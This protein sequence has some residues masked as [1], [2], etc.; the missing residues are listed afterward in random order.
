MRD[1]LDP[2]FFQLMAEQVQD[3]AIFLLDT[4]G[5]VLSW[6]LGGKRIKQ[7]D[8]SDVIG[9]HFS[10]FY[11]PPDIA[12]E[13]PAEELE[14]ALREG[15]FEDEGWRV[16]KD[17]SRFWA[18]VVI[19]ALRDESGKLIAYSKV[20]RDLSE[21]KRQDEQLRQSEERFRLLVEGVSDY[22]I[23]LLSPEGIVTS[24]NLGARRIKGYEA[25]EVI[26]HHF[27]RFYDAEGIRA[28]KPW[29]ELA[30]AREHGRAEDEGW[31]IRKDGSRFWAKVVVTALH[32]SDGRLQGFAKVTQDL[33]QRQHS[34]SLEE[35]AKNVGDFIAVLAHEL[36]NPLAPIR[37]AIQLLKSVDSRDPLHEKIRLILDRQSNQ[38]SLIVNDLL[39]VNRVA[40]GLLHLDM[41]P[42]VLSDVVTRAVEAAEPGITEK[43]HTLELDIPD[44]PIIINGDD[45]RLTQALSNIINNATRYS[46]NGGR[47]SIKIR[48]EKAEESKAVIVSVT[49]TGHGIDS[50]LLGSIFG[51]FVQGRDPLRS[52]GTG[53]GIGLALARSIVELHHGT[54]EAKSEGIGRGSEFT[55]KLPLFTSA[56]VTNVTRSTIAATKAYRILVVDDNEDAA[57][58]LGEL[59]TANGHEV[60][61]VHRGSQ[62]IA[63]FEEFCPSIVLLDIGMPGMSGLEVVRRL[64]ERS[65][66][67]RP[68][69][70][71]IT[72]WG[73][74]DDELRSRRAGFDFHLVK[75]VDEEKILGL[76][77]EY[78]Q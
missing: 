3:Y 56:N 32:G 16:K 75:P 22:A 42:I 19:T 4:E 33:T 61:I 52:P 15:R 70:V 65:R 6:N 66:H 34:E 14:R 5:R 63:A 1:R 44:E 57:L 24:W 20:T 62:A 21:R 37:N 27:S 29:A 59:L 40:R 55:I 43:M 8:E 10:M 53:L 35:A 64:R 23:Y 67:P 9:K 74:T 73:Q 78:R 36:R 25:S 50:S 76:I 31:R 48:L 41:K 49:D 77:A 71:A 7:Y 54:I 47:I 46:E 28:G 26:G 13:W 69:I 39:D 45:L 38:L 72:G 17:G 51:M 68:L 11:T 30:M 2:Y 60:H 58:V 12:R 18:N